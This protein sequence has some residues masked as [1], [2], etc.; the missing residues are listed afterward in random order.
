MNTLL[1][2]VVTVGLVFF[3]VQTASSMKRGWDE[4]WNQEPNKRMN[5]STKDFKNNDPELEA[6]IKFF[7][8]GRETSSYNFDNIYVAL[9]KLLKT[10]I[11]Y[12]VRVL[13]SFSGVQI[14]NEILPRFFLNN[15]YGFGTEEELIKYLWNLGV[16]EGVI[17]QA[18]LKAQKHQR[19]LECK[20]K[21]EAEQARQ[22][23][24]LPKC[25]GPI[26]KFNA[27]GCCFFD[28]DYDREWI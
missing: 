21:I 24:Y 12:G 19:N 17:K 22:K 9:I 26:R 6:I 23:A 11:L 25:Q 16:G 18:Q 28:R 15:L 20:K 2:A 7:H 14:Q 1:L 10:N 27:C 3:D 4:E 5:T 13:H 8:E